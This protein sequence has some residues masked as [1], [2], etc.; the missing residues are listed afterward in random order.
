MKLKKKNNN[1]L[2]I[3]GLSLLFFIFLSTQT[4]IFSVSVGGPYEPGDTARGDLWGSINVVDSGEEYGYPICDGDSV[5][6]CAEVR[7]PNGKLI[8]ADCVG[9]TEC[10]TAYLLDWSVRIPDN[11]VEGTYQVKAYYYALGVYYNPTKYNFGSA[12]FKVR[13]LPSCDVGSQCD[14]K[15]I[16]KICKNGDVY[17]KYGIYKYDSNCDCYFDRYS[18]EFYKNCDYECSNGVCLDGPSC[19]VGSECKREDNGLIC[20]DGNVYQQYKIYN[21]NSNC[22]CIFNNFET[23][24]VESCSIGCDNGQCIA[25]ICQEGQS[26]CLDNKEYKVCENNA[27]MNYGLV[28]DKCG[29][30]CVTDNDCNTNFTCQDS[31]CVE[32]DIPPEPEPQQEIPLLYILLGIVVIAFVG[33]LY[34]AFKK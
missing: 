17:K 4:E 10:Y 1:L 6:V 15:Y 23:S 21:Y 26:E 2:T 16:E 22:D 32:G 13:T 9:S 18:T 3:L 29:V 8:D 25:E 19:D 5:W 31:I 24:L 20:R 14:K 33:V 27:W 28:I 11:A 7:D 12:S 34:W 30:E